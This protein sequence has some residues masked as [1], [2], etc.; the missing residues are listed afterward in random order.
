[1]SS[2]ESVFPY[3]RDEFSLEDRLHD[4]DDEVG[5]RRRVDDM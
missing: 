5:I 1:M 4:P 2:Y 3:P